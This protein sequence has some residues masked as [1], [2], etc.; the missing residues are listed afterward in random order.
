MT[1][2]CC[3]SCRMRFTSAT[4]AYLEACPSCGQALQSVPSARAALGY[5]LFEFTDPLTELPVAVEAALPVPPW[6]H[7][8]R[9][10]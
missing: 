9:Q 3:P 7:G 1:R 6:P 10:P 4:A 8:P 5:R 2:A